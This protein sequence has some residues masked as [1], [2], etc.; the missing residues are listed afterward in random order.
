MKHEKKNRKGWMVVKCVFII[1][2][3]LLFTGKRK[4]VTHY[5]SRT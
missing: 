5:D 1:F 4:R 3:I 2:L